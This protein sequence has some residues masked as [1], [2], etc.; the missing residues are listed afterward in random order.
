MGINRLCRISVFLDLWTAALRS[1]FAA[2][3]FFFSHPAITLTQDAPTLSEYKVVSWDH[4]F[5][6]LWDSEGEREKWWTQRAP[7]KNIASKAYCACG[8]QQWNAHHSHCLLQV[9]TKQTNETA[10][11]QFC[12]PARSCFKMCTETA[13]DFCW[14][15]SLVPAHWTWFTAGSLLTE[16][17]QCLQR[18]GGKGL[19]SFH[20]SPLFWGMPT[21]V[22]ALWSGSHTRRLRLPTS[23]RKP[24]WQL[25]RHWDFANSTL[26]K[27]WNRIT[28]FSQ[29]YQ[30]NMYLV[31]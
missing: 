8:S 26:R 12:A 30:N 16:C 5:D 3:N 29:R 31:F 13:W 6:F 20:L 25:L 18:W 24:S 21:A 23:V 2:L 22:S 28:H 15:R 17:A 11:W 4:L 19:L 27:T 14:R 1:V 7:L 9:N 10:S